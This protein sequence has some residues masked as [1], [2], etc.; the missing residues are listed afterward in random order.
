MGYFVTDE[1]QQARDN[2]HA[3]QHQLRISAERDALA[4]ELSELRAEIAEWE[5]RRFGPHA[6]LADGCIACN[7]GPS[8]QRLRTLAAQ[9]KGERGNALLAEHAAMKAAIEKYGRC[10]TCSGTGA[11][12]DPC[13]GQY[14]RCKP[15]VGGRADTCWNCKGAKL[16]N[17]A[18]AAIDGAQP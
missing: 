8:E 3:T 12:R 5:L 16:Q 11:P 18:L 17:W 10:T 2:L 15:G 6:D 7:V 4:A 14:C 1:L 9:P 13:D